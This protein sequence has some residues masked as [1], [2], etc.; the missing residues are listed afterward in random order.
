MSRFARL[1]IA[2]LS[3]RG[4]T[5]AVLANHVKCGRLLTALISERNEMVV[6]NKAKNG[7]SGA[8]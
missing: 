5:L 8:E 6:L 1:A 2:N 4:V 3:N 7:R